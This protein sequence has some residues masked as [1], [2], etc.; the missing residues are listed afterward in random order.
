[1]K[2]MMK[3]TLAAMLSVSAFGGVAFAQAAATTTM[4]TPMMADSVSIVYL[5]DTGNS[6]DNANANIPE[7]VT[8]ASPETTQAAQTEIAADA[9]LRAHLESE[10]VQL[11]NVVAIVTAADGSKVVYVR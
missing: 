10:K 6:S 11:A 4:A 8:K 7:T 9:A 1:M 5:K 2:P 3:I